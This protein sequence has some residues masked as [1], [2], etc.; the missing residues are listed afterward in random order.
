MMRVLSKHNLMERKM[1]TMKSTGATMGGTQMTGTQG[2]QTT[3]N[4]VNWF[5]IPCN[6]LDRA[7]NFYQNVFNVKLQM[8]EMQNLKMAWFPMGEMNTPGATGTLCKGDGY[9]PTNNGTLVY[10]SVNS[11]EQTLNQV[12]KNG[13]KVVR[14]KYSIGEYGNVAV[15]E[16]CEGN[17]VALHCMQ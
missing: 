9:T 10:F 12:T 11:I 14:P 8:Q 1:A 17:R 4:R 6:N 3:N 2:Q 16:D 15:F 5:E 13:G 7:T